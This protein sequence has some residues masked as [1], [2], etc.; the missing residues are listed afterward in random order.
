[1]CVKCCVPLMM[2]VEIRQRKYIQLMYI[3]FRN[4]KMMNYVYQME[5]YYHIINITLM[6]ISELIN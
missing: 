1:M 6:N 4:T 2:R 3:P 5:T